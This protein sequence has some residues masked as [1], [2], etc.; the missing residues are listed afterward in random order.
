MPDHWQRADWVCLALLVAAVGLAT[1]PL[2]GVWRMES[3]GRLGPGGSIYAQYHLLNAERRTILEFGQY[4]FR[5]PWHGGYMTIGH[6]YDSALSP[7]LILAL[8]AGEVPAVKLD[9]LL[10]YLLAATGMYVFGRRVVGLGRVGAAAAAGAFS[11]SGYLPGLMMI[12]SA[13]RV[14]WSLAPWLVV[15]VADRRRPRASLVAAA[16][17]WAL[18]MVD[19]ALMMVSV[20]VLVALLGLLQLTGPS[21]RPVW[22]DGRTAKRVVQAGALAAVL[23]LPKLV[24]MQHALGRYSTA[25][26]LPLS[27]WSVAFWLGVLAWLWGIGARRRAAERFGR[28]GRRAWT[29]ALAAAP[30][31][32]MVGATLL[33]P[34][35]AQERPYHEPRPIANQWALMTQFRRL[36]DL[37]GTNDRWHTQTWFNVAV[38]FGWIAVAAAGAAVCRR[39][40]GRWTV[41]LAVAVV[42]Q[43]GHSL[44][45]DLVVVSQHLPFLRRLDVQTEREFFQ[46]I[47]LLAT[48]VLCGVAVDRLARIRAG[49]GRT[50]AIAVVVGNTAWLVPQHWYTIR[51]SF[52]YRTPAAPPAP[53]FFSVRLENDRTDLPWNYAW[54]VRNVAAL[55]WDMRIKDPRWKAIVPR[56]FALDDRIVR[57][58]RRYPGR[59][60]WL[61]VPDSGT[62]ALADGWFTPCRLS[63]HVEVREAATVVINQPYDAFWRANHGEAINRGGLQGVRL[64][65]PG[66]YDLVLR[67]RP[68]RFYAALGATLAILIALSVASLRRKAPVSLTTDRAGRGPGGQARR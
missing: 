12:G 20:G 37:E 41:L 33:A 45:F 39:R 46:P 36:A 59:E 30:V 5:S 18:V 4:P 23:A 9:L 48:A 51:E 55:P 49:W 57:D 35:A 21:D 34:T 64:P 50:L 8:L 17:V 43:I 44:P 19:G 25:E 11:L 56:A 61:L 68:R 13:T 26:P 54:A 24:M 40:A 66:T 65:G 10:A 3:P 28:G 29:A 15:F 31:L 14:R 32:L 42:D 62:I 22:F 53:A 27:W 58:N 52:R 47:V 60:A 7:R 38:G 67:Y 16:A 1:W 2:F 63:L 6:P